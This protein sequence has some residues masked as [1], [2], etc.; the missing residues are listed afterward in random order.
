MTSKLDIREKNLAVTYHQRKAM[1]FLGKKKKTCISQ[2]LFLLLKR[3]QKEAASGRS[4]Q[5]LDLFCSAIVTL[6]VSYKS[7]H[8]QNSHWT[9]NADQFHLL[10]SVLRATVSV[11]EP[12]TSLCSNTNTYVCD[13][14]TGEIILTFKNTHKNLHLKLAI[15]VDLLLSKISKS[16]KQV[17]RLKDDVAWRFS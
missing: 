15:C 5:M 13:S 9:V 17:V 1:A 4:L 10:N 11:F 8:M 12:D 7:F 14:W 2:C 16:C 6:Y 3:P